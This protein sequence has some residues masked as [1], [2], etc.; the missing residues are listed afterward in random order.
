MNTDSFTENSEKTYIVSQWGQVTEHKDAESEEMGASAKVVVFAIDEDAARHKA[1]DAFRTGSLN[2]YMVTS[3]GIVRR[4]HPA[5]NGF[6]G[7]WKKALLCDNL[8]KIRVFAD[9]EEEAKKVFSIIPAPT[10]ER[11]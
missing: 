1:V 6:F 7:Y 5:I 2:E 11:R 9:N 8:F 10:F 4:M 3:D